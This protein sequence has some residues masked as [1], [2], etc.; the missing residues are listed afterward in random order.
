MAR[1]HR[2]LVAV[3]AA[4]LPLLSCAKDPAAGIVLALQTDIVVPDG[5]DAVSLVLSNEA[6]GAVLGT[7]LTRSV[8]SGTNTVRFPSTLVLETAFEDT[9]FSVSKPRTPLVPQIRISLV[10]I[11]STDPAQPLAGAVTVL[12]RV[13][14]TMPVDGMHSLRISLDALDEGSV[15]PLAS[16]PATGA[17]FEANYRSIK[18]NCP[19]G[20]AFDRVA[21]SC[22]KI[23]ELR[24]EDL[25]LVSEQS[26]AQNTACFSLNAFANADAERISQGSTCR[27]PL[28]GPAK[29]K[30]AADVAVAYEREGR[31]YAVDLS[32]GEGG[33]AQ[34]P[35]KYTLSNGELTLGA[36]LCDAWLA[37]DVAAIRVAPSAAK[38]SAQPLCETPPPPVPDPLDT[39]LAPVESFTTFI[40]TEV[41]DLARVTHG[42]LRV[43]GADTRY[44]GGLTLL[45]VHIEGP[46]GAAGVGYGL[47]GRPARLQWI[48]P[49]KTL[50]F[51]VDTAASFKLAALDGSGSS[52]TYLNGDGQ[53]GAFYYDALNN[54]VFHSSQ[55]GPQSEL[56]ATDVTAA[57]AGSNV[58]TRALVTSISPAPKPGNVLV[59]QNDSKLYEYSRSAL[60][61]TY[62]LPPSV[63]DLRAAV[64]LPNGRVVWVGEGEGGSSVFSAAASMTSASLAYRFGAEKTHNP[65][66]SPRVAYLPGS[67]RSKELLFVGHELGLEAIAFRSGTFTPYHYGW[68]A[69]GSGIRATAAAVDG[70]GKRC[71]FFANAGAV[72]VLGN[73]VVAGQHRRCF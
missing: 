30:S 1:L 28:L 56:S 34:A 37:G 35:A 71:V 73:E 12:R 14:T 54:V 26:A 36:G 15:A 55:N 62:T 20:A 16:G 52:A 59:T 57:N 42:D 32:E 2:P 5:I 53:P 38:R 33:A 3:A 24:G 49:T 69:T 58:L 18:S 46:P 6:S 66:D 39:E 70:A 41:A 51:Y 13:V 67:G 10:G 50:L 63:R 21:G 31:L 7:P 19:D 61:K 25:P 45:D 9:T 48:S 29:N 43:Y 68:V 64:P 72:K 47:P 44:P 40:T 27:L 65:G 23:A 17:A 8:V 11:H 4:A 60:E 22:Q